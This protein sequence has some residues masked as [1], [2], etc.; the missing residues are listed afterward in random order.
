M[1]ILFSTLLILLVIINSTLYSQP[2]SVIKQLLLKGDFPT[3]VDSLENRID[4]G[5]ELSDDE[6]FDLALSY[7]RLMKH[8]KAI[9]I[10]VNASRKNSGNTHILLA[11]GYS[12]KA[13]G[14][15]YPAAGVFQEVVE[16][17]ST[18][19]TARIEL[20]KFNVDSGRYEKAKLIYEYLITKDSINAYYIA[21]LGYCLY[22]LK[23]V[24]DAEKQ[25]QKAMFYEK[26]NPKSSL[27]L[28][29]IYYDKEEYSKAVDIIKEGLNQNG[30]DLPLNKLGAEV[31]FKMKKYYSAATQYQALIDMGDSTSVNYQKL[32]LSIYSSITNK[33]SLDIEEKTKKL[34]KAI[35]ALRRSLVED[36]SNPLTLTYI[37]FCYKEQENYE[38]AIEYFNQ[39]LNAMSPDY[40]D[41]VYT[42]LGASF[43]LT[44][45]LS[46]AIIA[47]N[48]SIEYGGEKVNIIF[49]LATVYDRYYEDKSVALA[50]YNKFLSSD[51]EKQEALI[52][53]A[54]QRID[55]LK[56]DIHFAN[57]RK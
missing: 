43:E 34:F 51:K 5:V 20:A 6:K 54:N 49:Q 13:I 52:A 38:A 2:D 31:L 25:L 44:G 55:E 50:H 12:L 18:N 29:K 28:A 4:L 27:W 3:V 10:L 57:G 30:M 48:K 32:G 22:K 19:I 26:N 37:G 17:D 53:Y 24:D 39:A 33:D 35:A 40:I 56:E 14:K 1:K 47:Y 41:N 16:K 45:K 15:I 36:E 11:L 46:E 9:N 21:Q 42:N 23:S 8:N 7:Q